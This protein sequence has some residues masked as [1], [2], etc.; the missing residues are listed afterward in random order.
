MWVARRAA[1]SSRA[2]FPPG[3]TPRQRDRAV[4]AVASGSTGGVWERP[5]V[6]ALRGLSEGYSQSPK[7]LIF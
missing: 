1:W 6:C 5:R 7:H 2:A 4:L 3:A